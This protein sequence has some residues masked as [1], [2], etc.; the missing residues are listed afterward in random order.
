[1]NVMRPILAN[2]QN[3]Q[4]SFAD[5]NGTVWSMPWNPVANAPADPGGYV[6]TYLFA[7]ALAANSMTVPDAYVA[8]PT[9]SPSL[10]FLQFMALFTSAE[11]EAIFASSDTQT[12][13]FIQQASSVGATGGISLANAEVVAGVNYLAETPSPALIA[14]SR[15]AQILAG[16]IPTLGGP[17]GKLFK[18]AERAKRK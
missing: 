10:T 1:M 3:T 17:L 4:V 12:K 9:P 7:P 6:A 14:S 2:A 13:I 5:R 8:P 16:E 15:V 18:R 11:Q